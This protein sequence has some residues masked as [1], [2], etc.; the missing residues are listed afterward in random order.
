V[1]SAIAQALD[2]PLSERRDRHNH[3]METLSL[4]NSDAWGARFL[5]SLEHLEL[6]GL[7]ADFWQRSVI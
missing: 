3:I 4:N 2:M 6:V 7:D 1:A 5:R